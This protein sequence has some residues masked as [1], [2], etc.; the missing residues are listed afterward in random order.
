MIAEIRR[1]GEPP[2]VKCNHVSAR[3]ALAASIRSCMGCQAQS[4][5]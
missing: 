1:K 2:E 4:T 5:V 3:D